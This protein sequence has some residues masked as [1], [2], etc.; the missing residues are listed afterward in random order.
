MSIYNLDVNG[1]TIKKIICNNTEVNKVICNGVVVYDTTTSVISE[2]D[3]DVQMELVRDG[4]SIISFVYKDPEDDEL[5]EEFYVFSIMVDIIS[6]WFDAYQLY[7]NE[8]LEILWQF[9]C[10]IGSRDSQ[11]T[12]Q[13]NAIEEI[14]FTMRSDGTLDEQIETLAGIIRD[15]LDEGFTTDTIKNYLYTNQEALLVREAIL[16]A[17]ATYLGISVEDLTRG[18]F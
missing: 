18:L 6:S 13:I 9:L 12:P 10:L 14:L 8:V 16:E 7:G 5:N 11:F 17:I 1:T 2:P 15:A 3:D 4:Y